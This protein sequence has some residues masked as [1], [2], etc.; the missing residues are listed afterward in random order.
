MHDVLRFWL[1]HGVD[2][3]R[4]DVIWHLI[5]D[6]RFRDNPQT[7][8]FGGDP[9]HRA[10]CRLHRRP[11]R[12]AWMI[13][14]L[15]GVV[16]EFPARL[17]VGEIYLPLERLVAYYGRDLG[18]THFP[19]NFSL[20]ET[21]WNA[22]A[23]ARSST[24]TRRCCRR[25][26]GRIGCSAI[27]IDRASRPA[28]ARRRRASPPCCCS[29]CAARPRSITATRSVCRRSRFRRPHARS[30]REKRAGLGLGRD[31]CRTPMQWDATPDAGF[32][33][34]QPWLPI[35]EDAA[36]RNVVS[37]RGD[38]GSLYN[39]YRRL[40]GLRRQ[41]GAD[42]RPLPA[43]SDRRRCPCLC[44]RAGWRAVPRGA[45]FRRH[46]RRCLCSA[47][48]QGTVVLSLGADRIGERVRDGYTWP[49][50]TACWSRLIEGAAGRRPRLGKGRD[51]ASFP[52]F[53]P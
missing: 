30:V 2:G 39:V 42:H 36:L 35:S 15:R 6:A 14:E 49:G 4:V 23:V 10:S 41:S 31:G 20:L 53:A 51:I 32:S 21:P 1:G 27:M 44:S 3:F 46:P 11:A 50:M 22:R 38:P 29:R 12:G 45:Q 33:S 24:A 8:T 52:L 34:A 40:I 16:D 7:R 5:K 9:P 18:G 13:R 43:D 19:F 26:G 37:H 47:G 17:L 25:A 48:Y 28:S